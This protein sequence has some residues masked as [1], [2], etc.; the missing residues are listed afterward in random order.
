MVNAP[1]F[2]NLNGAPDLQTPTRWKAP[3]LITTNV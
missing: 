1:A 2:G 3:V